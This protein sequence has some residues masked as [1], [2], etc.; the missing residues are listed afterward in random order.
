MPTGNMAS[1]NMGSNLV[2]FMHTEYRRCCVAFAER[3]WNPLRRCGLTDISF[4]LLI[5]SHEGNHVGSLLSTE[6]DACF[7]SVSLSDRSA[8]LYVVEIFYVSFF[9][10]ISQ[11]NTTVLI[12]LK[13]VESQ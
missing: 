8:L 6:N 12:D 7:Q 11:S 10:D 5:A 13:A 4:F 3:Y 9:V 2:C 1:R